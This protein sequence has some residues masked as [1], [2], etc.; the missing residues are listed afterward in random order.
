M[1]SV[2]GSARTF[3]SARIAQGNKLE[4]RSH[5]SKETLS[6]AAGHRGDLCSH[7]VEYNVHTGD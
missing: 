4:V 5:R 3:A 1:T 6:C 2:P 7:G